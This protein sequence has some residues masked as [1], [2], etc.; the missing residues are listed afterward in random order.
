MSDR[1]LHLQFDGIETYIEVPSSADFSV[2]TTGEL[3]V[4]A[5]I[6]PET[7]AFPNT[8]GSGYVHWLGKGDKGQH[9]W[10]FRAWFKPR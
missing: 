1:T 7:L 10:A 5:W 4:S 6:R 8:E 2:P 9:E 3:T